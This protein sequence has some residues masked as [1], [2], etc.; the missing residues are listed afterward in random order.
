MT[1]VPALPNVAAALSVL[2]MIVTSFFVFTQ[3]RLLAGRDYR[4]VTG[5][6]LQ[7]R[8]LRLRRLR[9]P[10]F[11]LVV[12]YA[13]FSVGAPLFAL[14]E[15]ALRRNVFVQNAAALFDPHAFSVQPLLD[16]LSDP[17]VL[18][19]TITSLEAGASV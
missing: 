18:S 3:R 15:G 2:L 13:L 10:A 7:A 4:T 8:E 6:G 16:A 17:D 19:G 14:L 1:S 12:A 9:W 11:A 5:K